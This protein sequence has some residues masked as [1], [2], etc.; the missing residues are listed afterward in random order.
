MWC[1]L[2]P[3]ADQVATRMAAHRESQGG[4]HLS[5]PRV[6]QRVSLWHGKPFPELQPPP[7]SGHC[8]LP[9]CRSSRISDRWQNCLF[10]ATNSPQ[11]PQFGDEGTFCQIGVKTTS[12]SPAGRTSSHKSN[13]VLLAACHGHNNGKGRAQKCAVQHHAPGCLLFRQLQAAS[14][15]TDVLQLPLSIHSKMCIPIARKALCTPSPTAGEKNCQGREYIDPAALKAVCVWSL[16]PGP[17]EAIEV[18]QAAEGP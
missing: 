14:K 16:E 2:G 5:R 3:E 13:L 6:L 9:L 10:F 11:S 8:N 18:S 17:G 12:W 1:R 15:V 7:V 4:Q